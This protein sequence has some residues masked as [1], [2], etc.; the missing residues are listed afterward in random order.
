MK[1]YQ[2]Q[3][4]PGHERGQPLHEFHRRERDVGGT[5]APRCLEL[6]D[7][8]AVA[9]DAQ[10]LVGDRDVAAWLFDALAIIGRPRAG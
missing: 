4:R 1:P 10:S 7:C 8:V 5:V 6:E 2:V 3:T 9:V